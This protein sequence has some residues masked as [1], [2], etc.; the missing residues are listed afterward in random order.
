MEERKQ[1]G[2]NGKGEKCK[3]EIQKAKG[4]ENDER[5]RSRQG[6]KGTSIRKRKDRGKEGRK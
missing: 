5:I 2:K 6:R 4:R 1:E 3:E